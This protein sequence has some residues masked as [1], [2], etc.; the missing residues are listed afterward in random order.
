[1]ATAAV[2]ETVEHR[3]V[4]FRARERAVVSRFALLLVVVI[5]GAACT[6]TDVRV[7]GGVAEVEEPLP[8]FDAVDATVMGAGLAPGLLHGEVTVINVWATWCQ[9]CKQ[10]QP[11]LQATHE[12]YRDRGVEFL[13]INY[14]DDLETARRWVQDRGVTYPSI[15]DP[16]GRTAALLGFPFLP[17]TYVVDGSGTIRY[18]VYGDTTE[19]ELSG[20]IDDLLGDGSRG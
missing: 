1:M 8:S 9:P 2:V 11:A 7:E 14:N 3:R 6:G 15:Y 19:D 10:E 5:A 12:R 16:D 4:E 13:G 20:L 18:V 17:D